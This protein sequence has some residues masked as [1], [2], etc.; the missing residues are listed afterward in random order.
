MGGEPCFLRCLG[1]AHLLLTVVELS[2]VLADEDVAQND[3]RTGG[4]R[5]V[6]ANEAKQTLGL[7]GED[8]LVWGQDELLAVQSEGDIGGRRLL[9]AVNR[10]LTVGERLGTRLGSNGFHCSGRDSQQRRA[11]VEH[12]L[13]GAQVDGAAADA[14]AVQS[15]LPVRLRRERDAEQVTS[16]VGGVGAADGQLALVSRTGAVLW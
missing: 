4:G 15:S 1:D 12:G 6:D 10:V 11:G 13:V 9:G 5:N 14:E 7:D 16:V 2:V 3:E 8:V